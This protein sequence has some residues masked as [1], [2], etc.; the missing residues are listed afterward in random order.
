MMEEAFYKQL[1]LVLTLCFFA[2]RVYYD[3]RAGRQHL[4][5]PLP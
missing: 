3:Y 5:S 2:V 1:F 4:D